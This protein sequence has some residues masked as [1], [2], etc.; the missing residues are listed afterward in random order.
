MASYDDAN[1]CASSSNFLW[2]Q[3][4]LVEIRDASAADEIVVLQVAISCQLSLRLSLTKTTT[5]KVQQTT[6]LSSGELQLW[7]YLAQ[8]LF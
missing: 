2:F 6:P 4:N 1:T 3:N 7:L 5:Y 8:D